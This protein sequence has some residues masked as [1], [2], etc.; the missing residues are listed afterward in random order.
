MGNVQGTKH[1]RVYGANRLAGET[2]RGR[3]DEWAKCSVT[4][5]TGCDISRMVEDRGYITIE[6]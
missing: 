1:P 3:N 6:C 5:Q 2:S 4:V